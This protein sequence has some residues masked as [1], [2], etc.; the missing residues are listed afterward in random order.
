MLIHSSLE[1]YARHRPEQLC[2]VC[3]PVKLTYKELACE[4]DYL[5]SRLA[6]VVGRGDR[7]V[8]KL[9][10]PVRQL[11]FF[12]AV[13]KAGAATVLVDP[14]LPAG[15]LDDLILR[16]GA[17]ICI[18]EDYC[19]PD[20]AVPIL[21]Q[22]NPE[23][24]FLVALSSGS[25]G[26][27]KLIERDHKSWIEAFPVQS[28][29]FGL[30]GADRLFLTG[31]MVYTANLNSLLHLLYEGGTIFL[32]GNEWPRSWLKEIIECGITS[33][34]MVPAN[35]RL[36]L[37]ILREPVELIT[38]LVSG[39]AKM[40]LDTLGS[41]IEYFPRARISEYYGASELGHITC[42]SAEELFKFPGTVGKAF[43]GVKFW[44]EDSLVWVESPY[45]AP[46]YRPRATVG[47]LGEINGDGYLFVLGRE[48]DMIN[49]G[50]VKIVPAQIEKILNL[51]PGIAESA[52]M[53]VADP[54][55]GQKVV[56]WVVSNSPSLTV[57]DIRYFCREHLTKH[58]RPHEF[59]L[60]SEMPRN[61][62][63]KL[64]RQQLLEQYHK[65]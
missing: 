60:I 52:V 16:T 27:P 43:P 56:A 58:Y 29:V 2:L 53:G 21:P 28:A 63:G 38:S 50:G 19:L 55:R 45:V 4:T 39:G 51:C 46:H 30:D 42:A 64:D 23:D 37:K 18:D 34:F 10:N 3:G 54:L 14:A 36:L 31:S 20:H 1:K 24:I 40:D 9:S 47:D 41:L 35:Y 17:R 65:Q 8:I 15:D 6:A 62:S 11:C 26:I 7:V 49:K 44:T 5:A 32:A 13:A 59:I 48:N 33:I 57:K 61:T 12:L 25:T 22:V